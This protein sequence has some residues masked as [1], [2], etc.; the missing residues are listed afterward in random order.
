MYHASYY[1]FCRQQSLSHISGFN[2]FTLA[3]KRKSPTREKKKHCPATTPPGAAG[4]A[5]RRPWPPGDPPSTNRP[6]RFPLQGPLRP[7][8]RA[9][10][11]EKQKESPAACSPERSAGRQFSYATA[12]L[13]SQRRSPRGASHRYKR[14]ILANSTERPPT[15]HD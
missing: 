5:P 6:R 13:V 8:P 10:P 4:V 2:F 11:P 12:Q 9:F 1:L 15:P 7:W 3:F 14:P